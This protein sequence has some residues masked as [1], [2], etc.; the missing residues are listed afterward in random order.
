MKYLISLTLG[1][2]ERKRR[3]WQRGRT[4]E[5]KEFNWDGK[6]LASI[7]RLNGLSAAGGGAK[8]SVVGTDVSYDLLREIAMTSET[9]NAILRRTVDDTLGNGYKFILKE[10]IIDGDESQLARARDLFAQPSPDDMG[11]E[12][13]ESLIFDL[14]LYGDGFLELSGTEDQQI[15]DNKWVYGGRLEAIYHVPAHTIKMQPSKTGEVPRPP[16]MAY[17][18][19]FSGATVE[20]AADKILHIAKHKQGRA[21]GSSPLIPLLNI[22]ASYM[23]LHTY[24]GEL[25]EGTIPKTILN[26]GDISN[27][28]MKAMVSLIEQQL[29]GSKSPFGLIALNG[30]SGFTMHQLID[31]AREGQFLDILYYYREQ[32]CA[33]FG[34]PPMKLGWVQT[35]KL[36]NPEQ[37]LEAWYDCID[38]FHRRIESLVN[39]R[40]MPLLNVTDYK[41]VFNS[42]R[43][44]KEKQRSEMFRLQSQGIAA[45]RQ[46]SAISINEAREMLNLP[47]LSEDEASDP[48][49][50]S[51]KLEI[52]RPGG[53][54]PPPPP[55]MS[56][57]GTPPV[58]EE[59]F[60]RPT[61]KEDVQDD[62]TRFLEGGEQRRTALNTI[63]AETTSL[64]IREAHVIEYELAEEI[65]SMYDSANPDSTAFDNTLREAFRIA[66]NEMYDGIMSTMM[67]M[68][69]MTARSIDP[70]AQLTN[71]D[72]DLLDY[73]GVRFIR[74]SINRTMRARMAQLQNI[75][76]SD[77]AR[78][79][80]EPDGSLYR[81]GF[82]QRLATTES[83]RVVENA[84]LTTYRR[85]GVKLFRRNAVVDK[86]TDKDLCLPLDGMV[87]TAAQAA[88]LLPAH[89]NCRCELE[90]YGEAD[91]V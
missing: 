31:S 18:Q 14:Q 30:G 60:T 13:L 90:P 66:G 27:S 84:A 19:K 38:S 1:M 78:Q 32:I 82:I 28:E 23:N 64:L 85:S 73:W 11:D 5:V 6:A 87:Y 58:E 36:S 63:K 3:F 4:P 49:Y 80:L 71:F 51:P 17:R 48:F 29:S 72:S 20:F 2:A 10:G 52:N 37:Q 26:V 68:Y 74:P 46:E 86:Q 70:D 24:I 56:P 55:G 69:S 88:D 25:F 83:A 67:T 50:I 34:I 15:E 7:G 76:T 77:E 62:A 79:V 16:E 43:P 44:S 61:F 57:V 41:F 89:P 33:V 9:V 40:I 81:N 22:I 53:N 47:L 54:P 8:G 65:A 42:I 39:N 75:S 91:G 59:S 45:L 12:W 35:G 21:Y